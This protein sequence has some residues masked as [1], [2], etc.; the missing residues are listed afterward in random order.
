[1]RDVL[2]F[3]AREGSYLAHPATGW[4]GQSWWL[5]ALLDAE[6]EHLTPQDLKHTAA[7]LL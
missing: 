7:S 1:M 2:L 6:L 4:Y 3:P 5:T